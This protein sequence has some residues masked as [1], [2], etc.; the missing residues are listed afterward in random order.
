MKYEEKK[1]LSLLR[2]HLSP[3]GTPPK[4]PEG[5]RQRIFNEVL[6]GQASANGCDTDESRFPAWQFLWRGSIRV[7]VPVGIVTLLLLALLAVLPLRGRGPEAPAT[8]SASSP[9]I[10]LADF[11]PVR[12]VNVRI[13]EGG[14]VQ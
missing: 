6:Q 11:Q 7:P 10:N 1:I 8:P 5:A 3:S 2:R 9:D 4:L 14:N 12:D 13:I